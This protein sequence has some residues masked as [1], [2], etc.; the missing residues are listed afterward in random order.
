METGDAST[1]KNITSRP[2]WGK[3][4][5]DNNDK[6]HAGNNIR[7]QERQK[8]FKQDTFESD[9]KL[10]CRACNKVIENTRKSSIISHFQSEKHLKRKKE[11]EKEVG[12]GIMSKQQKMVP[13]LFK[14]A[15]L[16]QQERADV[17]MEWVKACTATNIPL[18]KSHCPELRQ[19]LKTQ[20][21]NGGASPG[22]NQ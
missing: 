16:S 5:K 19:F 22:Y 2:L 13:S 12:D 21:R 8:E 9:G 14:T 1:F 10:F 6:S 17:A 3:S 18:Y 20:V 7:A 15:T 11:T 4:N